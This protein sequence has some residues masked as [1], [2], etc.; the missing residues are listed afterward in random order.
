MMRA[1][2]FIKFIVVALLP[3][4]LFTSCEDKDGR[5]NLELNFVAYYDDQP[6]VWNE[7]KDYYGGER[8]SLDRLDVFISEVDL[9]SKDS[10]NV[11]LSKVEL[12]QFMEYQLDTSSASEGIKLLYTNIEEGEYSGLEFGIGVSDDDNSKTPSEFSSS[13][14]L[15]RTSYYWDS[16]EGYIFTKM[17]GSFAEAGQDL[18]K[19]FVFHTGTVRD[20]SS[21]AYRKWAAEKSIQIRNDQTEKVIIKIDVRKLF[22]QPGDTHIDIN[23]KSGSHN[24]SDTAFMNTLL[25]NYLDAIQLD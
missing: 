4:L 5:G 16:W 18:N 13:S 2:N 10:R 14:P 6:I 21:S 15:S 19:S 3:M 23:E 25:E 20:N 9:V 24:L 7:V 12:L 22:D 8:I 17:E 11:D 1:Y